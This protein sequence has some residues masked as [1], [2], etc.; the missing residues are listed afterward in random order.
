MMVIAA[1]AISAA[2][3]N[4]PTMVSLVATI[5]TAEPPASGATC[6]TSATNFCRPSLLRAC[7]VDSTCTRAEPS[8]NSQSRD[9]VGWDRGKRHRLGIQHSA[10]PVELIRQEPRQRAVGG[11][12]HIVVRGQ[13]TVQ[14]GGDR[15]QRMVL[16]QLRQRRIDLRQR[17]SSPPAG[18]DRA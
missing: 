16:R 8:G 13:H 18:S 14:I 2:E 3:R 1:T 5:V 7:G 12:Q 15:G 9:N 10:Q 4:A 17:A 11:E 6:V